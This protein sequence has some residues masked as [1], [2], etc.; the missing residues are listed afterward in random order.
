MRLDFNIIVTH[1][2]GLEN[3]RYVLSILRDIIPGMVVVDS[4]PAII[5]LRV[6]DPYETIKVLR[7]NKEK[8]KMIY[9][10]TPVD[11]ITDAYVEDVAEVASR[12]AEEIIP[13]NKTY[14]VT[15]RG[16]LFWKETKAP[17]HSL[18]AIRVIA[19]KINRIV[20]LSHP[21]YVVYVR[22]IRLYR[23]RI[24]AITVTSIDN[25]LSLVSGKP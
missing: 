9:R 11:E 13:E 23:R 10:I 18:D 5:L 12:L 2:P 1:E 20:S 24:A 22:S 7:E 8:L 6:K 17:A 21:D 25:I 14:R 19:E 4:A 15:L 3:S 16:R